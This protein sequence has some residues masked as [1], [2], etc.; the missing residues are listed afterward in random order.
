M[1]ELREPLTVYHTSD[2]HDRRGIVPRLIALRAERPG[3]LFDCGDSLRG[4]QTLYR[5]SEPIIA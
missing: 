1:S 2:L 4:S 3:L 5:A